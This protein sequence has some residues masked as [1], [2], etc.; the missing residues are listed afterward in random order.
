MK[1]DT[2]END[3]FAKN[4]LTKLYSIVLYTLSTVARVELWSCLLLFVKCPATPNLCPIYLKT[5]CACALIVWLALIRFQSK[6][7]KY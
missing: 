4:W 2:N 3:D 1:K 7:D 5:S 6:S